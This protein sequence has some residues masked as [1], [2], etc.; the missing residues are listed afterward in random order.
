MECVHS[1]LTDN[2]AFG[3]SYEKG[4][5]RIY[6]SGP[7]CYRASAA[8]YLCRVPCGNL[9]RVRCAGFLTRPGFAAATDTQPTP[10]R[11]TSRGKF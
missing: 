11:G 1:V 6:H 4:A 2:A 7:H 8:W 10:R 9:P 3:E 5:V